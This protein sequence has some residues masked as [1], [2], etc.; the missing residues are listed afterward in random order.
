MFVLF[1]HKPSGTIRGRFGRAGFGNVDGVKF[2]VAVFC[3]DGDSDWVVSCAQRDLMAVCIGVGIFWRDLYR[4]GVRVLRSGD[5]RCR[6]RRAIYPDVVMGCGVGK[7]ERLRTVIDVAAR[8][9][10]F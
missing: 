3:G 7:F 4:N 9:Q 5:D 10:G 2:G 8:R 6:G 1:A